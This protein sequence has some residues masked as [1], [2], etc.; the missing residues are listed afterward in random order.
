MIPSAKSPQSNEEKKTLQYSVTH[1]KM[2]VWANH[3][4]STDVLSLPGEVGRGN[5]L[6]GGQDEGEL[7]T[8]TK[9]EGSHSRPRNHHTQKPEN[10]R[11]FGLSW[12][13]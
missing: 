8:P 10:R 7:T 12:E 9:C 6:R 3:C 4:G 1:A 11:Q 2:E 13:L 5:A